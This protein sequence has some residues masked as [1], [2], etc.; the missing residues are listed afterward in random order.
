MFAYPIVAHFIL[1]VHVEISKCLRASL[2]TPGSFTWNSLLWHINLKKADHAAFRKCKRL[3]LRMYGPRK[4]KYV[5][6][7]CS[8]VASMWPVAETLVLS[9]ACCNSP[10]RCVTVR[11]AARLMWWLKCMLMHGVC[12][13]SHCLKQ[14]SYHAVSWCLFYWAVQVASSLIYT[15]HAQFCESWNAGMSAFWIHQCWD[16]PVK[17][18]RFPSK[19]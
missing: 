9:S 6:A 1:V 8:F 5:A 15:V 11:S 14:K 3:C 16:T 10:H 13:A 2:L 19:R 7:W 18:C 12:C 4:C 17:F